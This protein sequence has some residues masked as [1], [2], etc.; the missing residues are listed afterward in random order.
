MRL[1]SQL[2]NARDKK[3]RNRLMEASSELITEQLVDVVNLLKDQAI[4]SGQEDL[5]AKLEEIHS[6]LTAK[7]MVAN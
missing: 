5:S 7:L 2:V 3:E 1:L 4:N 6:E